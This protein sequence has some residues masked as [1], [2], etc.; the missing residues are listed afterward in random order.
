MEPIAGAQS[1]GVSVRRA[2]DVPERHMRAVHHPAKTYGAREAI[3][4]NINGFPNVAK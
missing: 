2:I 3:E 4:S 1:T